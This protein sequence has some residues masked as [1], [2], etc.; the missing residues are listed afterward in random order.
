VELRS[1]P[2]TW[3]SVEA[4]DE[5]EALALVPFYVAQRATV[6]QVAEVEIP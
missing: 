6:I 5:E 4:T 2:S 1:A 3:W